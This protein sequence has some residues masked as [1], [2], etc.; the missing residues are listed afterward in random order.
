LEQ[1]PQR[2]FAIVYL[3]VLLQA[4]VFSQITVNYCIHNTKFYI[5]IKNRPDM[6]ETKAVA[7]IFVLITL[8]ISI[9]LM[10]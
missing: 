2:E 9:Q 3:R 4:G 10:L 7:A 1:K 6:N 5:Q 8:A